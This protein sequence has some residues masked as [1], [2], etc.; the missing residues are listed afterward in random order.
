M[1]N[2]PSSSFHGS[3]KLL[4]QLIVLQGSYLLLLLASF[5]AVDLLIFIAGHSSLFLGFL[6]NVHWYRLGDCQRNV[7]WINSILVVVNFKGFIF[8]QEFVQVSLLAEVVVA[9]RKLGEGVS[10]AFD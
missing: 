7:K 8:G 10:R 9:D 3:H 1:F 2:T 4:E 5:R 6:Q